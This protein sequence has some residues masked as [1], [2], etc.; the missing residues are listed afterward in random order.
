MAGR[1]IDWAAA[2]ASVSV[3]PAAPW[4][5]AARGWCLALVRG[6]KLVA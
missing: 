6:A 3:P 1:G 4:R 2:E 5:V